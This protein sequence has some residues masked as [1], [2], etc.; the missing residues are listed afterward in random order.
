VPSAIIRASNPPVP[1]RQAGLDHLG[2]PIAPTTR[3]GPTAFATAS[4]SAPGPGPTSSNPAMTRLAINS[5]G[6]VLRSSRKST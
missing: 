1:I 2:A 5:P 4:V 3:P 6:I